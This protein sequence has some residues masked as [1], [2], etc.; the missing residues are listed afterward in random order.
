[1]KLKRILA[2]CLTLALVAGLMPSVGLFASAAEDAPCAH[3]T[4]HT[5]DCGYAP[6][7]EGQACTHECGEDCSRETL[8]C[9]HVHDGACGY[10]PAV[11][12]VPEVPCG[13]V[14]GEDCGE[15]GENCAHTAHDETCGYTA[16]V[17]AAAEVPCTHAH[18]EECYLTEPA[19]T[20]THDETCG[21]AEATEGT[22]C[23]FTCP[24]CAAEAQEEQQ[25]E[26][27]EESGEETGEETG[28]EPEEETP[29]C[30]C[31]AVDGAHAETC[32]LYVA[33]EAPEDPKVGGKIWIKPG[34]TIYAEANEENGHYT[35][36]WVTHE[37]EIVEIVTDEAGAPAWYKY[38]Y[39]DLSILET[40]VIGRYQYVKAEDTSVENPDITEEPEVVEIPACSCVGEVPENIA[41]HGDDCQRKAF[42]LELTKDKTAEELYANWEK[43]Q[44]AEQKDILDVLEANNPD[45]WE[46]L[47]QLIEPS[48]VETEMDSAVIGYGTNLNA[49]W[50]S[51][52]FGDLN[53]SMTATPVENTD[54]IAYAVYSAVENSL[55]DD[56]EVLKMIAADITFIDELGN[57]VQPLPG[58]S[59]SLNFSV[60]VDQISKEANKI[61]IIHIADDGSADVIGSRYLES[62]ESCQNIRVDATSFSHYIVALVNAKYNSPLLRDKL[63]G[64]S[65]YSVVSIDSATVN[66]FDY[67]P[68][69][70]NGTGN[71][72]EK[73]M[74]LGVTGADGR[75]DHGVNDSSSQYANQGIL[76]QELVNG[77]PVMQYGEDVGAALFDPGVLHAG[78]TTYQDVDFEFIYDNSTRNYIYSSA[79]NHAQYNENTHSVDLYADTLGVI[80]ASNRNLLTGAS[81]VN[82]ARCTVNLQNEIINGYGISDDPYFTL[83]VVDFEANVGDKIVMKVKVDRDITG[84]LCQLFFNRT[85][86]EATEVRSFKATYPQ[87]TASDGGY[88]Y[89]IVIDTA[90]GS[91]MN[92]SSYWNGTIAS[93]RPDII[94]NLDHKYDG[95]N[96]EISEFYVVPK[97]DVALNSN[98][99]AGFYPFSKIE[100][101]YPTTAAGFNV[102]TWEKNIGSATG[103]QYYL[104]SRAIY[105]GTEASSNDHLYLGMS[106]SIP[107]YL[108]ESKQ[109]NGQDIVYTFNGDDDLWVF[110]DNKLVLD[111]GGGH[112][113][114]KGVINFTKGSATVSNAVQVTSMTS[115]TAPLANVVKDF[116]IG[117]GDHTMKIF[118]MERAGSISN[119]FMKFNL[120][121]IP[122]SSLTV[123]KKVEKASETE[124][125]MPNENEQF[126]FN[127]SAL[128]SNN[129]TVDVNK[130][131][132]SL[133]GAGEDGEKTYNPINS[134]IKLKKGQTARFDTID[135]NT[136]V[137]V[138][139]VQP[140]VSDYSEY[141]H[142]TVKV[143]ET[144]PTVG[145]SA[146]VT[147]KAGQT[148]DVTFTNYY[149]DRYF[150]LTID[151]NG[152][153]V[154]IDA[155]QTFLF[156]VVCKETGVDM[157]V[158]IRGNEQVTI[159]HLRYGVY[160]VTE[161]TGWSWRYEPTNNN[162]QVTLDQNQTVTFE[163]IRKDK[164]WFDGNSW[165]QNLLDGNTVIKK[166]ATAGT[167]G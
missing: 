57:H 18:T 102:E 36:K 52:V 138:V 48:E 120:P 166:P 11:A 34:S 156:H 65:R 135:E 125:Y 24:D 61:A 154:N 1:M 167:T 124:L 51:T 21:Y 143:G 140:G 3:H 81:V 99:N 160:V 14:H 89:Q 56:S 10:A 31:E 119:C 59:V 7:V 111:V 71:S 9:T 2:F 163:N 50:D 145:T 85:G 41:Q 118:Y 62:V 90:D 16:A 144:E 55:G 15:N 53:A 78:K 86:E 17:P 82:P 153:D 32:P 134:Q 98:K 113:M 19:C 77:N 73:F 30:N 133:W 158:T 38:Q 46:A 103:D 149:K 112:G 96:F 25:E 165:C 117:P 69:K 42:I 68:E 164:Q 23:T 88:I 45:L 22:P 146:T 6:A 139:E 142:A 105:N 155:N 128:N 76:K 104:G 4:V 127:I 67:E 12:E 122:A 110:I 70:F 148:K 115:G 8:N 121:V 33:P 49:M 13:H 60:S 137:T 132:Y 157:N 131:T 75:T 150:D 107:F 66:L 28:E 37:V 126:T 159:K 44:E 95:A 80:N 97:S 106:A 27:G 54:E 123:E 26:P 147:T 20:H 40:M 47:N 162:Q 92:S 87:G 35:L 29:V 39:L 116:S 5:P 136:Q 93:F 151:K 84:E 129:Q 161:D 108:P 43:F 63:K 141:D 83:D 72:T 79:I 130:W 64:D 91:Y 74:F 114:I 58:K 152:C 100:N 109:V 94:N 101:S